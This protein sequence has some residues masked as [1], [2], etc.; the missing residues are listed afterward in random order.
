MFKVNVNELSCLVSQYFIL[1]LFMFIYCRKV[2]EL[3]IS[4]IYMSLFIL[5]QD[6]K[7]IFDDKFDWLLQD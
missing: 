6:S 2:H 1:F 4:D 7:Y 5:A 3:F